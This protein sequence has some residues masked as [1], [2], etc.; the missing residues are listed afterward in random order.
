[1][2]ATL[3]VPPGYG[4][5]NTPNGGIFLD[6]DQWLY[7]T[8]LPYLDPSMANNHSDRNALVFDKVPGNATNL[9]SR[10]TYILYNITIV[11]N[12]H[13]TR[14]MKSSMIEEWN[15]ERYRTAYQEFFERQGPPN[16]YRYSMKEENI[17]LDH[18]HQGR[19]IIVRQP[20]GSGNEHH[21]HTEVIN[22][23]ESSMLL[24]GHVVENRRLTAPNWVQN[25]RHIRLDVSIGSSDL[26]YS[27]AE[28]DATSRRSN[29]NSSND[30]VRDSVDWSLDKLPY[31]AGDVAVIL[32]SNTEQEVNAFLSVLPKKLQH[33]ADCEL[34]I[35]FNS[36]DQDASF[37]F[38]GIGY[39]YWP[40]KCTLR[41]LLTYCAD[42]HALPERE[43]LRA[44]AQY[45]SH[46]LNG[47]QQH[48]KLISL[49]ETK[50][51]ALYVDYI[52]REKRSWVDVLYDFD[53][54]RDDG[55]NLTIESLLGLLLPIRPRSFS[56]ASSPTKDWIERNMSST[57]KQF[58][59]ELCVGVVEGT[60]KRGRKFHGLCSNYLCNLSPKK[61][62]AESTYVRLWIQ[63]GSFHGL[64]LNVEIAST[65]NMKMNM[66]RSRLSTP[67]LCIGAGT[68][69][70]PLRAIIQERE[71]NVRLHTTKDPVIDCEGDN[72][73][74]HNILLFG[75]RKKDAD[76]YYAEEWMTLQ[77]LGHLHILAAYSQ[78]QQ[79]KIYVQ[80]V[81]ESEK[82]GHEAIVRHI[83]DNSGAIYIAGG[84]KM[85]RAVNDVIVE[86][87]CRCAVCSNEKEARKLLSKNQNLGLYS[88]E[89]WS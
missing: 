25:T 85:A 43:D 63:P 70:A 15:T 74:C 28:A 69:V 11:S 34:R 18:D 35:Q 33:L 54:L 52:L 21:H 40:T 26:S 4:D 30:V 58:T 73:P 46:H 44:L 23:N 83:V 88:V 27:H 51:S 57:R 39:R 67:V 13:D 17:D 29:R 10:K 9:E 31:Q 84:P 71:A 14:E 82:F 55:S 62:E 64:P 42:I 77:S 81:L 49:S 16:A 68:G 36:N 24:L 86:A 87:L 38:S 53:S 60:T 12:D 8:V 75:C 3:L 65:A 1:L 80:Q 56:I 76:F 79:N 37:I 41:G 7:G 47:R 2:G 20:R 48:D 32:P 19:M 72:R 45:C 59:V 6:L 61:S 78:D 22:E 5:D 50:E 66:N 89:A